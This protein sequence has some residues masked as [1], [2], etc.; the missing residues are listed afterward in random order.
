ML[1]CKN[2]INKKKGEMVINM[3]MMRNDE[4]NSLVKQNTIR[5]DDFFLFC[6]G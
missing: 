3:E 2:I 6:C 1:F 5:D 4:G